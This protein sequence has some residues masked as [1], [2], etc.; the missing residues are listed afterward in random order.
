METIFG[1]V[2][3]VLANLVYVE[4]R[5]RGEGG[6]KRLVAFWLGLP[7]TFVGMLVVDRRALPPIREDDE[8]MHGLV[9]EI[10]RERRQHLPPRPGEA[11]ASGSP[12]ARPGSGPAHP[13][14][15]NSIEE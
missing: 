2:V 1:L 12:G 10:R 9:E 7:G 14:G 8:G 4:M 15:R 3:W 13:R 11:D 5:R 6:F